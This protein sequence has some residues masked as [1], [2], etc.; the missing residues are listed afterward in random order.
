MSKTKIDI[1]TALAEAFGRNLSEPAAKL[2]IAALSGITD[3]EAKEACTIAVQRC[4]F[5]PAAAELIEFVRTGGVSY[6]AQAVIAFEQLD[7]ALSANKPSTM[8]PL[9]AAVTRQLGGFAL[10]HAMPLSELNTWK[11]KEFIAAYS[12]ILRENPERLAAL[13][14]PGS[15][16]AR[17]LMDSKRIPNREET[18][19]I[20]DK[21]RKL[22][23]QLP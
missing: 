12:A 2:Y 22:L 21:N 11:R 1:V 5:F 20:E 4:K 15:D 8:S 18:A 9:V 14:S 7:D 23:Q 3:A 13:A 19:A 17:A 10:L 6:E 16:I